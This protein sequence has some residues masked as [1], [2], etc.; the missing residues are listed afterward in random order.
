[1][2]TLTP[3]VTQGWEAGNWRQW[4]ESSER[5]SWAL[6]PAERT[7]RK[8]GLLGSEE[9]KAPGSE[10]SPRPWGDR[11][12]MSRR[13]LFGARLQLGFSVSVCFP[14]TNIGFHKCSYLLNLLTLPGVSLS[15][16]PHPPL[17]LPADYSHCPWCLC[18]CFCLCVCVRVCMCVYMCFVASISFLVLS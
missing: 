2:E 1:M 7:H 13:F 6:G 10:V 14:G 8:E 16:C 9:V 5:W 12:C 18:L 11:L 4:W 17:S 15:L 3:I